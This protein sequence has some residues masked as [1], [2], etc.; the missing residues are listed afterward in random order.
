MTHVVYS[1]IAFTMSRLISMLGVLEETPQE[2]DPWKVFV[3]CGSIFLAHAVPPMSYPTPTR[4]TPVVPNLS[5]P[6]FSAGARTLAAGF[7]A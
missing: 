4:T 3:L 5:T 2:D 7:I 1:T 6:F